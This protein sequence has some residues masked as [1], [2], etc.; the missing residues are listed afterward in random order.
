M[1]L[2]L[3]EECRG[4]L[5]KALAAL[6]PG[7]NRDAR[8][9]MKLHAALAASLR[10]SGG[11][12]SE[13]G[14][15]LTTALEIAESLEDPEYQ[16]RALWGLWLFHTTS[17]RHRVALGLAQRLCTLAERWPDPN[18]RLIGERA[19]GTRS[20]IWGTNPTRGAILRACSLITSLP[21]PDRILFGFRS[22][23]G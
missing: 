17:A 23:C 8:T 7:A 14:A 2:S 6:R 3:L 22:T 12:L 4:R 11:A 1:Q 21:M 20:I 15:A 5:E 13:T 18:D 9:E 10:Y 19:V 16:L